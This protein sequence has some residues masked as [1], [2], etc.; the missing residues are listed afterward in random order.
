MILGSEGTPFGL[1]DLRIFIAGNR[2]SV[3]GLL[4]AFV[5]RPA[6][7]SCRV[8]IRLKK[9]SIVK[10]VRFTGSYLAVG[11]TALL[12]S[13][14]VSA[15]AATVFIGD[16]GENT[17][18]AVG[19]NTLNYAP[20]SSLL[21]GSGM[22]DL[23]AG[24]VTMSSKAYQ[25]SWTT[26][27]LANYG[28]AYGNN[29]SILF[30]FDKNTSLEAMVIWNL[31]SA[32]SQT[33]YGR[34][35]RQAT[36]SYSTGLDTSG[37]GSIIFSGSLTQATWSGAYTGTGYQN[38]INGLTAQN[39]KAV[40]IAYTENYGSGDSI[41]LSEVRFVGTLS[42]VPEIDPAGLGSVLALLGGVLGL[43]ER[44]RLKVA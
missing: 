14:A 3:F 33:A 32:E 5:E 8:F 9:E 12:V 22:I 23:T 28:G 21:D 38:N 30:T 18:T 34:G 29:G 10:R 7:A 17:I 44:R 40:K 24:R 6:P 43:V 27:W 25:Q 13:F 39:V 11:V 26:G 35:V 15:Q 4:S 42:A 1:G 36:I 41:G 37:V 31:S 20:A 16:F 2:R 19:T